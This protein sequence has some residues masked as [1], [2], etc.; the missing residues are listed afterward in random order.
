MADVRATWD[1]PPLTGQQADIDRVEVSFR[2]AGVTEWTLQDAIQPSE[3][4]ELVFADVAP[5]DWEYRAVIFDVN[6]AS[7]DDALASLTVP[8]EPPGVVENFTVTLE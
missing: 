8:F 5:G 4:Q 6:G 7:G 2:V 3:P 1:L